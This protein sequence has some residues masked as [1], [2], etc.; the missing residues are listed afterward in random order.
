V[1]RPR[2]DDAPSVA[3]GG[4]LW[5]R[6]AADLSDRK[7][8]WRLVE[9]IRQ[10][11]PAARP[12][13]GAE[14]PL[15][16][17]RA[18]AVG[19]L[20]ELWG[21]I[22][23]HTADGTIA[24]YPPTM[25]EHWAG[26]DGE[27]GAFHR[28]VMEKHFDADAGTVNEWEEYQG[29]IQRRRQADA[30][31]Q[32]AKRTRDRQAEDD[33]A[34]IGD[35]GSSP[36]DEVPREETGELARYLTIAANKGMEQNEAMGGRYNPINSGRGDGFEVVDSF[37]RDG[38]TDWGIMARIIFT[39]AKH[40]RPQKRGDYIRSLTFFGDRALR[41]YQQNVDREA[42]KAS[43]APAEIS[44]E[45]PARQTPTERGARAAVG[46]LAAANAIGMPDE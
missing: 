35:V 21:N 29:A 33:L 28:W 3:P 20:C 2:D 40:Y 44:L 37:R 43:T 36:I 7:V 32:R 34:A 17:L 13:L 38:V 25:L 23:K 41:V 18:A 24:D 5:I 42:A 16:L 19:Y 12:S 45:R 27:P 11:H 30:E 8:T 39:L 10:H 1:T 31:R 4:G 15:G 46:A 9:M 22:A 26:W 6:V 14:L